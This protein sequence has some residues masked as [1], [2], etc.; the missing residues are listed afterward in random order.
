MAA[1]E[2]E[3]TEKKDWHIQKLQTQKDLFFKSLSN[4]FRFQ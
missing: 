2:D 4:L 1:K 3:K